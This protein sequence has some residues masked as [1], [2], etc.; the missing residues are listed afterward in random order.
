MMRKNR[1]IA[2]LLFVVS[3]AVGCGNGCVSTRSVTDGPR[4]GTTPLPTV[5]EVDV[6]EVHPQ[7]MKLENSLLTETSTA[8]ATLRFYKQHCPP[9]VVSAALMN[10]AKVFE[11]EKNYLTAGLLI[12][13]SGDQELANKI[14]ARVFAGATFIVELFVSDGGDSSTI[15]KNDKTGLVLNRW[16][17]PM[18]EFLSGII[19]ET[20]QTLGGVIVSEKADFHMRIEVEIIHA[21]DPDLERS[22]YTE[23]PEPG[24]NSPPMMVRTQIVRTK[25]PSRILVEH[26]NSGRRMTPSSVV[27]MVS[28]AIF[29]LFIEVIQPTL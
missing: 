5:S 19:V 8:I 14:Y 29:N 11:K 15:V 3:S 9:E 23:H 25:D 7:C 18:S 22:F 21:S 13:E 2:G 28:E 6:P 1:K 20:I 10:A 12:F 26:D 27:F 16:A 4:E 17:K 24:M